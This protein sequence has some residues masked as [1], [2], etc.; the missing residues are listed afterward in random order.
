MIIH[1][2][3]ASTD[4]LNKVFNS[5]IDNELLRMTDRYTDELFYHQKAISIIAPISRLICDME[6]F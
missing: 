3:H 6:R 5:N 1:I 2:P 4:T